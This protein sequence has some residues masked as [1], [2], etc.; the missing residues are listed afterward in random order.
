MDRPRPLVRAVIPGCCAGRWPARTGAEGVEESDH[1]GVEAEPGFGGAGVADVL[2]VAPTPRTAV[3]WLPPGELWPAIQD[4]RWEHDP[5]IRRWPPH[6]NV[7]FGFVPEYEF[8]RA[9][10]LLASAAARTP[11]FTARLHGVRSFRHREYST[12]WFDPAAAGAA[13]WAELYRALVERFPSCH[14]RAR[15]FTPHLSLGRSR[16]P[17]RLAA[18]CDARLGSRSALVGEVVL[19]SRRGD[20]PMRPRATVAL[21]TG[22]VHWLPETGPG[23]AAEPAADGAR[24]AWADPGEPAGGGDASTADGIVRRISEALG[25]GVVRV[26][27]SRRTGCALAGAGLDLVAALPGSVDMAE[28]RARVGAALPDAARVR[29]ATGAGVPGLRLCADGLDVCLAVVATGA[30]AP[31]EAVDRRAELGEAASIALSAVSDADA[32]RAAVGGRHPAFAR[33]ARQVRAWARAR[34]LD[35]APFGGL[36]GLAWSLLA[37]RTVRE[38]GDLDADGL[39]RHFFARWAVWDW[40][41]PVALTAAD[42]PWP[43]AVTVLT[44]SPPVRSCTGQV[45]GG[46][47]ELLSQELYRAWEVLEAAAAARS[48]PWPELLSPPPLHRRH[49]AWAVVTVRPARTEAPEETL[50]RVRGRMRALLSALEDAGVPDAHAWPRPFEPAPAVSCFAIGLGRTPPDTA[51]L[52]G[53]AEG[54]ARGL[55]AVTVEL[56]ECGAVPTLR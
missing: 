23:G 55:P 51:R 43:G 12:V 44:P 31:A 48:S 25:E 1:C 32:V 6:V 5:Q 33:L 38:A 16:D 3:A 15:G 19:L 47:A 42:A 27:G 35:S 21:G 46:G 8:E 54:W 10:P 22:E 56:V 7:L 20:E 53:I 50:D 4:I 24:Q 29:R 14:G 18:E 40:R 13:P 41:D 17:R 2:D 26:A 36:P 34:G 30:L 49:A 45:G 28:V 9:A 39:L 11:A 52:A 37:A